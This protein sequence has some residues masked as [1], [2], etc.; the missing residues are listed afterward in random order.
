ML[1]RLDVLE[2]AVAFLDV[3]PRST[4]LVS[5]YEENVRSPP[6]FKIGKPG[7]FSLRVDLARESVE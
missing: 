3:K 7:K 4:A 1:G 6:M 5:D 2:L